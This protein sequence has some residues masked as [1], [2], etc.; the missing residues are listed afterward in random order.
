MAENDLELA[1]EIALQPRQSLLERS[2]DGC[3][4]IFFGGQRGGGKSKGIRYCQ[5]I[6]RIKY[7]GTNG[8][9]FRKTFPDIQ[10]N[11]IAPLF[12][13][14]PGLK[15]YYHEGQKV[16]RIPTSGT[17]S[18]LYFG[19]AENLADLSKHQGQEY[20]DL[21]V[22]EKGDWTEEECDFLSASN[23]S[24]VTGYRAREYSAGNPGGVGHKHLKRKFVTRQFTANEDPSDY[25]F[26]PSKLSDNQALIEADPDYVKVLERIKDP[27][28]RAA[29]LEGSWDIAAGQYFSD[30]RR[31]IHVVKAFP[32]PTHWRKF[33]GYDWGYSHPT[34]MVFIASDEDGN[35]YVYREYCKTQQHLS[36]QATWLKNL[37][38]FGELHAAES[39]TDSFANKLAAAMS[40]GDFKKPDHGP[41][42]AEYFSENHGIHLKKA[43]TAR[44]AGWNHLRD[45]LRHEEIDGKRIGPR[46]YFFDTCP[47]T[48]DA[49]SR[50]THDPDS[51]E[52]VLKVDAT[53]SDPYTGDDLLDALRYCLMGRPSLSVAPKPVRKDAWAD[54]FA[55]NSSR[56][57]TWRTV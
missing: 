55:E 23:R 14:F 22:D 39:G 29:W 31:D 18:D 12:K 40:L 25:L 51:I 3:R 13:E 35:L 36:H 33:W 37:P 48:I 8:G 5:L 26:I 42:I 49:V 15:E 57:N 16:L 43:N 4:N 11:H 32:L 46:L 45:Y 28:L 21:S 52:D 20:N 10:K 54:A 53:A 38:E 2:I 27:V 19:Y 1:I 24:S 30:F 9:I 47:Q 50:A 44:I 7:P 17:T 34:A 41:T 6:R 56:G